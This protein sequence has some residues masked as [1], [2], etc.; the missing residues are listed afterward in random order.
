M[1]RVAETH[2]KMAAISANAKLAQLNVWLN[3]ICCPIWFEAL[4]MQPLGRTL[5][6]NT[7]AVSR[8]AASRKGS[9]F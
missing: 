3:D 4:E 7:A 2:H 5:D 1:R 9:V 6:V 8:A